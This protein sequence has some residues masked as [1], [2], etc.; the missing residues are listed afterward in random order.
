MCWIA[1][2]PKKNMVDIL[3]NQKIRGLDALWLIDFQ[4]GEIMTAFKPTLLDYQDFIETNLED[5]DELCF[6]HHRKASIGGISLDNSHPFIW[7]KF[8]LAQNGTSTAFMTSMAEVYGKE[9]DSETILHFLE[10]SADT[11]EECVDLLDLIDCPL[12][13]IFI[14]HK[15][16]TLIYSDSCRG[17]YLEVAD[18]KEEIDGKS[19]VVSSAVKTFTNF[20]IAGKMEYRNWFYII[21]DS[22]TGTIEKEWN[23]DTYYNTNVFGMASSH[24]LQSCKK[25]QVTKK[26]APVVINNYSKK[27]NTNALVVNRTKKKKK[28]KIATTKE[29]ESIITLTDNYVLSDFKTEKDVKDVFLKYSASRGLNANAIDILC[30]EVFKIISNEINYS[31]IYSISTTEV[32]KDNPSV[33]DYLFLIP[34]QYLLGVKAVNNISLHVNI[35]RHVRALNTIDADDI[36][37][38]LSALKYLIEGNN[39]VSF[40]PLNLEDYLEAEFL[41][42]SSGNPLA[43]EEDDVV[44]WVE[45]SAKMFIKA[46]HVCGLRAKDMNITQEY[47]TH[48][49]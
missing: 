42:E 24:W 37:E 30:E 47:Y 9:T 38:Y 4:K 35:I 22:K 20:P 15:G 11:L 17:S 23:Y 45:A 10:D 13:I 14:F 7:E 3:E 41:I 43:M 16:R 39:V 40:N 32:F 1:Y 34:V 2:A 31:F 6:M 48:N 12:G 26:K 36:I 33:I 28:Q 8:V 19:V 44:E 27:N 46:W 49:K 5:N 25:T 29:Y 18:T 21:C